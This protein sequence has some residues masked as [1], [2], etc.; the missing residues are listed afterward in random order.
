VSRKLKLK[1][2]TGKKKKKIGTST[3]EE[4]EREAERKFPFHD[5]SRNTPGRNCP[6]YYGDKDTYNSNLDIRNSEE[7]TY[8]RSPQF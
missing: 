4:E 2:Q 8:P 5:R 6:T 1:K 3:E 7:F